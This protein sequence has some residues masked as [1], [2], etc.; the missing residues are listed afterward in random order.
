LN[1]YHRTTTAS[2]DA[3]LLGGFKDATGRYMTTD[4]HSGVWVTADGP[5]DLA[6]GG[7]PGDGALLVIEVP[8]AVFTKHEWVQDVGYREALV[9]A[10]VLNRYPI[11]R[12][13][14]C[15]ECGA[16]AHENA[17]GWTRETVSAVRGP[18]E[19]VGCP[20]C[21]PRELADYLATR[22]TA[23][24]PTEGGTT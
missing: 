6:I 21:G 1:T 12:A 20:A 15:D 24:H 10:E 23:H 18:M 17:P 13:I 2:A 16:V 4:V 19:L 14:E 8:G 3:I 9:P 11:Y 7:V 22:T 5:W